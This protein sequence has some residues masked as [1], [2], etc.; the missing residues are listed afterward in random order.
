MGLRMLFVAAVAGATLALPAASAAQAPVGQDSVTGT[1]VFLEDP[2]SNKFVCGSQTWVEANSGPSGE[3]PT[4]SVAVQIITSEGPGPSF[5]GRVTCL[6]VEGNRATV[7]ADFFSGPPGPQLLHIEDNGGVGQDRFFSES[8]PSAPAQCPAPLPAG[9][10]PLV[11]NGDFTVVDAKP[12]PRFFT[13]AECRLGGWARIG[14]KSRR[15]CN[16]FVRWQCRD[17]RHTYYGFPTIYHCR[18]AIRS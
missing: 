5:D 16:N 13:L 1:V 2:C 14:F 8:V 18:Q 17:G 4:G 12:K 6:S 15:Q 7:G 3:S 11:A 9:S 10:G